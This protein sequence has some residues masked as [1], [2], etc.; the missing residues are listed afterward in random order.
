MLF[1][2]LFFLILVFYPFV[3]SASVGVS[4]IMYDVEGADSGREW[5][6]IFNNGT[7]S[8]DLSGW[9]L[10][11]ADVN[12][13]INLIK[14]TD[15][16]I[17]LANAFAVIADDAAKFLADW[18][19]F[20]GKIFG[21]S[22][23]LSN[24]GE[25][26]ILRNSELADID[27]VS[28]NSG[29]GANGNG[30]SLQKI[31][32]NWVAGKSTP[33][34]ENF[35][36]GQFQQLEQAQNSPVSQTPASAGVGNTAYIAPEKMPHIK[37]DAGKDRITLAGVLTEFRGK[38]YGL[39]NEPLNDARFLWNFGDGVS[40]DGQNIE[41]SYSYPGKYII[42]LDVISGEYSASDAFTMDVL[43]NGIY[44]SEVA[45]SPDSF[46]ELT[47]E[48]E[49]EIDISRW[50]IRAGGKIFSLPKNTFILAKG[51]LAFSAAT[52]GVNLLNNQGKVEL[53]YPGNFLADTF[54][55]NGML[56]VDQ[57]F[58]RV[59]EKIVVVGKTPGKVNSLISP[60]KI[61]KS[62]GQ[63]EKPKTILVSS[64]VKNVSSS[65]S[66]VSPKNIGSSAL[67]T[68]NLKDT[69]EKFTGDNN[70]FAAGD[71][72]E[73][74]VPTYGSFFTRNGFR[75]LLIVFGIGLISG[76]GVFLIRRKRGI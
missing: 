52:M 11:E 7:V 46:V 45:P 5:L 63:I 3:S 76:A 8:V 51:S 10:Y 27:S 50:Q 67:A 72:Q 68:K 38:A 22:F 35:D 59:D 41:H 21:S 1:R 57:S 23:S 31:N 34:A 64:Q 24:T 32:G 47:N 73:A 2:F 39:T 75:Y 15:N 30:N 28:Y 56:D 4:E 29:Q 16:F 60:D 58:S 70:V 36:V 19:N 14:E 54:E 13:K 62:V 43:P 66:N 17:L 61:I 18:P 9:R 37:A 49:K 26:L 53:L 71:N 65:F 25:N 6:E 74:S 55:Y 33:G 40:K 48:L 42:V 69:G 12:H 20:S 44:I